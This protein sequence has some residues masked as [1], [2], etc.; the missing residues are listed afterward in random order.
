VISRHSQL[1]RAML[2]ASLMLVAGVF[3]A[4]WCARKKLRGGRCIRS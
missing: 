1:L 4:T 3:A 2:M